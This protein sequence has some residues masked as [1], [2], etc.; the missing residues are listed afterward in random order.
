[1]N[2]RKAIRICFSVYLW[3]V[4]LYQ[5]IPVKLVPYTSYSLKELYPYPFLHSYTYAYDVRSSFSG[6]AGSIKNLLKTLREKGFDFAL[7]DFPE[8]IESELIPKPKLPEKCVLL[9]ENI[10]L[11][12]FVI[13]YLFEVVP[14]TLTRSQADG[15]LTRLNWEIPAE[16]YVV[17]H[18][19]RII[20]TTFLGIDIPSYNCILS[21]G[22]NVYFSRDSLGETLPSDIFFETVAF[23]EDKEIKI[24]GYS[25][26]S[27]YLPGEST[28]F[29]FHLVV[30]ADVKNPLVFLYKDKEKIGIYTRR[31][32]LF[33]ADDP[34]AYSVIVMRY[35]F[36]LGIFYF[37]IRTLVLSP[38]I[39]YLSM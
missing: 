15:V 3:G 24:F 11:T 7:G 32:V 12:L 20:L 4:I 30:E 26:R 19:G 38:P 37:G 27:F 10:P 14:K 23:L 9:G 29:P 13:H 34:G 35:K 33:A 18:R 6:H 22:K 16:C 5:I 17:S 25:E 8:K 36:K 21:K 28:F 31:R 1:M 39:S 2:I